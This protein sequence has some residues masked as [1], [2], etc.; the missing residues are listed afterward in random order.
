MSAPIPML[1]ILVVA[2]SASLPG[3]AQEA[4]P[5]DEPDVEVEAPPATI[6]IRLDVEG[7]LDPLIRFK[8]RTG[9]LVV[10]VD[11]ETVVD[12]DDR[13]APTDEPIHE[14]L[15]PAGD[16]LIELRWEVA[17][18]SATDRHHSMGTEPEELGFS[19]PEAGF[20]SHVVSLEPGQ[21]V[22]LT[23]RLFRKATVGVQGKS[24]VEWEE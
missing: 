14:A 10:R 9:R 16:H 19:V 7:A 21:R 23:A 17:F 11:G 1:A 24:W 3:A 15:L 5:P 6:V 18:R 22:D 4:A 2:L 8:T 13:K 12:R 20:A